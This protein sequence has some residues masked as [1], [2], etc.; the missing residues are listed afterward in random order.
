M[1][2]WFGSSKP[3][4]VPVLADAT[5]LFFTAGVGSEVCAM[6]PVKQKA[7]APPDEPSSAAAAPPSALERVRLAALKVKAQATAAMTVLP[8]RPQLVSLGKVQRDA[9]LCF[10][11]PAHA[12]PP[13][14]SSTGGQQ[15]AT[16]VLGGGAVVYGRAYLLRANVRGGSVLC[17]GEDRAMDLGGAEPVVETRFAFGS[18]EGPAAGVAARLVP[19]S[20]SGKRA[21]A[22]VAVNDTVWLFT[23][24]Q[25]KVAV[26]VQ[27]TPSLGWGEGGLGGRCARRARA[28]EREPR[29]PSRPR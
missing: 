9:M 27:V 8:L 12:P 13:P 23:E 7:E 15:P 25:A 29:R 14:P 11:D 4:L 19:V 5:P 24:D 26:F 28:R 1:S 3:A 6:A 18:G 22:E 20:T 2:S 16:A 21:G 17:T 10:S